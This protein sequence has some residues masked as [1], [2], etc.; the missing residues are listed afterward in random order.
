M[1]GI[2]AIFSYGAGAPPVD[3]EELVRI[4]QSMAARGPDGEGIWLSSDGRTG[5]AHRRLAI[6]D[7]GPS[8][9]QPMR[10]ESETGNPRLHITYNGEIYNFRQ[11]R[12]ELIGQ[13]RRLK[14]NSD[15]EVLLHLYDRD[16]PEMVRHLRGM[17][18]FVIWDVDRRG[19]FMARD[20]FGIK[21]LYYADDGKTV[22]VASQ[23]KSLRVGEV[24]DS[25]PD[26]AGHVGFFL[27][28]YVPEPHTLFKSIQALPAGCSYWLGADGKKT[29]TKY[30]NVADFFSKRE[31]QLDPISLGEILRESLS[32]SVRH[33][34]VS[35]VPVGAFLSAGLDSATVTALAMEAADTS[36][37][38]MTL[39]FD[40]LSGTAADEAPLADEIARQYGTRH[41]VRTV[42][43]ADFR[44]DLDALL[45]AMDQP[46]VDGVNTYFV[47]KEAASMGLKVALS[48]VG[49]DELFGGYNSFHQ[50]PKLVGR[51]GW[52]PGIKQL[53][54]MFRAVSA[55]ILS[56]MTSPKY[57]SLFEYSANYGAAYFLRRGLYMPWELP[58]FLDPDLVRDGWRTL[59]L[60]AAMNATVREIDGPR[61]KVSALETVW[62]MRN[63]LLRD[64]DWAGMA[65]SLEIRTPLVDIGLF[66]DVGGLGADKL[67]MAAT[68]SVPLPKSVLNRPKTGFYVPVR[69]WLVGEE[70][71]TRGVTERGL[72][73][74]AKMVYASA[75][76]G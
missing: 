29:L 70:E 23:V 45:S 58:K 21:P 39:R 55:P 26:P 32:E 42:K 25:A 7:P 13:G 28:G 54:R 38:T 53:G 49:G 18:A 5:L 69:E 59:N 36:L 63:Q 62:Y 57:A 37:E 65:H 35:D 75:L 71:K 44:M 41:Q 68:P 72:R 31:R 27:L 33:H 4:N 30:H 60:E 6:I 3:R 16:G 10:L 34:L 66:G 9:A 15:T 52:I 14:T 76:E 12:E 2:T 22:R 17:F 19:I 73:G 24:R 50:V 8:G 11:L 51:L 46:S 67:A 56:Q 40:E 43:G 1:C 48:G 47:A 74:W 61:D 64:T 20:P